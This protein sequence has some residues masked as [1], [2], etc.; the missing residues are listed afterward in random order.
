MPT[1]Q[2]KMI[3]RIEMGSPIL[4]PGLQNGDCLFLSLPGNCS[5]WQ[6]V[7]LALHSHL[8]RHR[9]EEAC[10]GLPDLGGVQNSA[11]EATHP[12]A[13]SSSHPV[14]PTPCLP[15]SQKFTNGYCW[16]RTSWPSMWRWGPAPVLPLQCCKCALWPL[17][18]SGLSDQIIGILFA[19]MNSNLNSDC[20][21]PCI[22]CQVH[23]H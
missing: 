2:P 5:W 6:W 1:R 18:P 4:N 21:H 7:S 23:T 17:I 22:F 13:Q 9:I 11:T 3:Y 10:V 8:S 12:Q 15:L 14:L 20:H 19:W 16:T